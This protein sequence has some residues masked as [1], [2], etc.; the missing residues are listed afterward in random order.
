[1]FFVVCNNSFHFKYTCVHLIHSSNRTQYFLRRNNYFWNFFFFQ[2][3]SHIKDKIF[4]F[5]PV[6][7]KN[8]ISDKGRDF[9]SWKI[10]DDIEP[11]KESR[12]E[13]VVTEEPKDELK[14]RKGTRLICRIPRNQV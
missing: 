2:G 1:M 3:G 14:I 7:P 12:V 5:D 11:K 13:R 6:V 4:R 9:D 8:S 10:W